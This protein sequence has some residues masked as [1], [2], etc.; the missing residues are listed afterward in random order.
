MTIT[1]PDPVITTN[2]GATCTTY[3]FDDGSSISRLGTDQ[4][5]SAHRGR[6]HVGEARP[7][8]GTA[9]ATVEAAFEAL[10]PN[11]GSVTPDPVTARAETQEEA[12]VAYIQSEI[13][14]LLKSVRAQPQTR[15]MMLLLV[16]RRLQLKVEHIRR[17]DAGE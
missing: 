7:C 6:K 3:L 16:S 14:Y 15:E 4:G 17:A 10:Y 2:F 12:I 9:F 8:L 1:L 13:D 5:W 11:E